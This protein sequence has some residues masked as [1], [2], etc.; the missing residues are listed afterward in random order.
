MSITLT[1]EKTILA[2]IKGITLK[3]RAKLILGTMGRTPWDIKKAY[4]EMAIK[5]Y[6]RNECTGDEQKFKMVHEA[7]KILCEEKLPSR[8]EYC[9]ITDE[10]L[11]AN[12]MGR[13]VEVLDF[14]KKQEEFLKYE[15][16]RR[17]KFYGN[18]VI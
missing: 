13:S 12:F 14:L 16:W 11:V 9:L 6:P 2:D 10:G 15:T 18:G 17:N 5:Y 4:R 1:S 8:L 7:Y 3:E